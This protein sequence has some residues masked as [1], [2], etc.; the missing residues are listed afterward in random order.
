MVP[1]CLWWYCVVCKKTILYWQILIAMLCILYFSDS[2]RQPPIAGL[3]DH[4]LDFLGLLSCAYNACR[5][6]NLPAVQ[7]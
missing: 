7:V 4:H 2:A 3:H 1:H 6:E 5:R